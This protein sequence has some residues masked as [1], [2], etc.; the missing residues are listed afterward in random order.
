MIT[1][2]KSAFRHFAKFNGR[3]TRREFWWFILANIVVVPVVL[4]LLGA[5]LDASR[6]AVIAPTPQS[7]WAWMSAPIHASNTVVWAVF[8]IEERQ[9]GQDAFAIARGNTQLMETHIVGGGFGSNL[10]S[11]WNRSYANSQGILPNRVYFLYFLVAFIPT[12]A[13]ASRRLQDTDRRGMWYLLPF[14][15]VFVLSVPATNLVSAP[16]GIVVL[17]VGLVP[18]LALCALPGTGGPN[19]YDETEEQPQTNPA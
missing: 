14:C 11:A 10:K 19:K 15:L 7:A 1:A 6:G 18:L 4:A 13:L 17:A 9:R 8:G 12:L 3:A 16:V 2:Y 5:A